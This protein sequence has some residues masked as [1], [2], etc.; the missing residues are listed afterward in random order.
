MAVPSETTSPPRI[1]ERLKTVSPRDHDYS[2][3]ANISS[4]ALTYYMHKQEI[5]LM[6]FRSLLSESYCP[7]V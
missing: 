7:A 4:F 6:N 5:V 3:P 1:V 2:T